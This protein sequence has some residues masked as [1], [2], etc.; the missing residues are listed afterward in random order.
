[1]TPIDVEP[2][3]WSDGD[4]GPG[5]LIAC[6]LEEAGGD[7][8]AAAERILAAVP[9]N[10]QCLAALELLADLSDEPR[11]VA[12]GWARA[13]VL[14]GCSDPGTRLAGPADTPTPPMPELPRR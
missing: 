5:H 11:P 3:T 9:D 1:M 4:D 2:T 13:L 7:I 8:R 14:P 10:A 6:L 12:A